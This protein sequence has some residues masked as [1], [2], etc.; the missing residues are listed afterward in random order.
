MRSASRRNGF[1]QVDL[2]TI[3]VALAILLALLFPGI[4]RAREAARRAT[5]LN[6]LRQ[7]GLGFHNHDSALRRFPA[8]CRV[9]QDATGKITSMDGWSWCVDMLP[10]IEWRPLWNTL[11]VRKGEP[12]DHYQDKTHPHSVA[13]GVFIPEFICPSFG[14]ERHVDPKTKFE[15]I[16]NYKAVG[17]THVES[18]NVASTKPTKPLYGDAGQHPDGA[19]Y[20]DSRH[21]VRDFG[22][23]TSHT[24]MV[25]ETKEQYRARWPVG[26]EATLVGLPAAEVGMKFEQDLVY[27]HP[28]GFTENR[29]GKQSTI[30]AS[31]NKTYLGW[32]YEKTLYSDGGISKPS[33]HA[34]PKAPFYGPSSDHPGV[35]NHLFADGHVRSIPIVVDAAAYMFMITRAGGDPLPGN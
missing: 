6:H 18:L 10:Y 22:D 1:T 33:P 12:L 23:G 7:L 4:F 16:T 14:G 3:L 11:D 20:P 29:W 8:S 15:A 31:M 28:Q 5:C 25:V 35:V 17:G 19:I 30:P 27:W 32:D 26:R 13:L 9:K 24:I 2:L 21:G 34:D